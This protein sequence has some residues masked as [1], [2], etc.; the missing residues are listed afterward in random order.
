MQLRLF[1]GHPEGVVTIKF[2][3]VEAADECVRLMNG[4]FFGGRQLEAAKWD[5]WTNFNVKVGVGGGVEGVNCRQR[6]GVKW[7]VVGVDWRE[8]GPWVHASLAHHRGRLMDCTCPPLPGRCGRRRRSS[9][10]GWSGLLGSWSKAVLQGRSL[11]S[12]SSGQW[13]CR[14]LACHLAAVLRL[15]ASIPIRGPSPTLVV[16]AAGAAACK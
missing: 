16:A 5:G 14:R 8:R 12:S 11:P 1:T 10:R 2:G 4:R 9:R 3:S 15:A 6:R 13:R 7:R